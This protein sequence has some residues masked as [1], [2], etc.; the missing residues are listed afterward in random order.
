MQRGVHAILY[1]FFDADER[2]DRSAMRR[3]VELCLG[4]GVAGIAALGLATEV[5]KLTFDERRTVMDWVAQDVAGAVPLGFTITGQS[6]AEQVAMVRHAE[7]VGANWLILQP[8]AVGS[9]D[10]SE[11]IA[12]FS[13]VIAATA[14]PVAIQNAPQYLGRGLSDA[15]IQTLRQ[16]HPNFTLI[17]SEASAADCA[18]LIQLAGP[19]FQVFNGRGGQEMVECLDAG[20]A[21][22]LL[23]PDLV[24]YGVRVM[25]AWDAGD[26]AAAV[27]L[28]QKTLPAIGHV[29]QSI[30]HLI[31]HGKRLFA[32][33]AGLTV[34][35]RAPALR[36]DADGLTQIAALAAHLG[37]FGAAQPD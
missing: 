14:L 31:C 5:A 24:D 28:H 8:P 22:F 36:P 30:E 23:A 15:D 16:S 12:F 37:P 35:D 27:A 2:L 20:C 9:Y 29:M 17:K 25:A 7:Q 13:R 4:A 32:Q 10:A 3:Q 26:R 19:G 21:G 1:A 11:Y 34:H 33:R 18:K 6:V